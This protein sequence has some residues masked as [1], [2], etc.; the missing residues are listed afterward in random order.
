MKGLTEL[1][2]QAIEEILGSGEVNGHVPLD[3][4]RY[5]LSESCWPGSGRSAATTAPWVEVA[6]A[7]SV[8]LT[9]QP[10][11]NRQVRNSRSGFES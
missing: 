2:I 7:P 1:D 6:A 4:V 10:P 9:P 3:G 5:E 11:W 8:A